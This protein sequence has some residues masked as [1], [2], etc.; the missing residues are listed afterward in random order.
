[1]RKEILRLLE[2]GKDLHEQL[3]S[4]NDESLP[5]N[6]VDEVNNIAK[7]KL[8]GNINGMLV[9]L[10]ADAKSKKYQPVSNLYQ[11]IELFQSPEL[12]QD[13]DNAIVN[14]ELTGLSDCQDCFITI[15]EIF[16]ATKCEIRSL[17]DDLKQHAAQ[18]STLQL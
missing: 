9:I 15:K 2:K 16:D 14:K 3:I 10:N 8:P 13:I 18:L 4:A 7:V 11:A 6:I 5:A 1:M 17:V 12:Q